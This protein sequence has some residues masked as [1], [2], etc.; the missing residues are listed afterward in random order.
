[1]ANEKKKTT[2]IEW[3]EERMPQKRIRNRHT[4]VS[5]NNGEKEKN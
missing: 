2:T 4:I 5:E 1:M 3:N